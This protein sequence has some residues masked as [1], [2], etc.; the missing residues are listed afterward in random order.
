ME[1]EIHCGDEKKIIEAK[2]GLKVK[3][4]QI[5]NFKEGEIEGIFFVEKANPQKIVLKKV[6][7]FKPEEPESLTFL[8]Q[9]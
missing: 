8:Y 3:K 1:I 6:N 9:V 7:I 2:K 5:I 4:N